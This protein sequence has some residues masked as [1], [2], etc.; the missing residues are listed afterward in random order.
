[1]A[2]RH[3]AAEVEADAEVVVRA[4]W[5][6]GGARR[7]EGAAAGVVAPARAALA[8]GVG[9]VAARMVSLMRRQAVLLLSSVCAAE[10]SV[11][12]EGGLL[13]A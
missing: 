5:R 13:L 11:L 2:E 3:A 9:S 10:G 7:P 12:R 6:R 8:R 4:A 1:M